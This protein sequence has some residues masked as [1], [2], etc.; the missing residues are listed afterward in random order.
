MKTTQNLLAALRRKVALDIGNDKY[1]K[2]QQNSYLE[3]V[4][5]KKLNA[6]AKP[7]TRVQAQLRKAAAYKPIQ[8]FHPQHLVLYELPYAH[9]GNLALLKINNISKIFDISVQD[10]RHQY[11]MAFICRRKDSCRLV[12]YLV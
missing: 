4:I 5:D 9:D 6:A 10:K 1:Q 8:P 7:S 2:A 3:R 12:L 11:M